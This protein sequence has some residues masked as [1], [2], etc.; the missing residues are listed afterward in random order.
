MYH[1]F[2]NCCH[3]L[4]YSY[5]KCKS[6]HLSIYLEGSRGGRVALWNSFLIFTQGFL[7]RFCFQFFNSKYLGFFSIFLLQHSRP[8]NKTKSS[9]KWYWSFPFHEIMYIS[10]CAIHTSILRLP[11]M[12]QHTKNWHNFKWLYYGKFQ[13]HFPR[14]DFPFYST[15]YLLMEFLF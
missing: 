5:L 6:F 10:L 4:F 11:W 1:L 15:H 13:F 2:D 9:T 7:F 8:Y 12:L 14:K 3:K